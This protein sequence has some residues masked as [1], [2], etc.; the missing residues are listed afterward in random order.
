MNQ[1]NHDMKKEHPI[2]IHVNNKPV[3]VMGPK[4]T[5]YEIKEA[6]VNAGLTVKLDFVLSEEHHDGNLTRVGDTDVITVN[7]QSK[8]I[9]VSPD[10]NS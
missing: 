6:A 1:N 7:P 10:H 2:T 9:M 4:A 8:F 5:G 3:E